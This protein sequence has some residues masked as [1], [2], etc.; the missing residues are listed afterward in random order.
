MVYSE[1]PLQDNGASTLELSDIHHE[2]IATKVAE[3]LA[4]TSNA[5]ATV[6]NPCERHEMSGDPPTERNTT[7]HTTSQP[8]SHTVHQA[9]DTTG[10]V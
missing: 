7:G 9:A 3:Q 2:R 4:G 6:T 8:G 10:I 5:P 1:Q